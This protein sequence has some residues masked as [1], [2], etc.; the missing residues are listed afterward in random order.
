M[1]FKT[2][3]DHQACDLLFVC[4]IANDA[5][6]KILNFRPQFAVIVLALVFSVQAQVSIFRSCLPALS[7]C[8]QLTISLIMEARVHEDFK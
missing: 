7:D 6:W 8:Y 2:L 4:S 5:F 1:R 3:F